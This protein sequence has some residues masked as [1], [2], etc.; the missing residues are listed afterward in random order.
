MDQQSM[1]LLADSANAW[2][3]DHS[4]LL[5]DLEQRASEPNYM[6]ELF[7]QLMALGWLDLLAASETRGDFALLA[8]LAHALAQHSA[9]LAVIVV[10]QNLAALLLAQQ[11]APAPNNWVTLPLLDA[12]SQWPYQ[13]LQW[14]CDGR[15][16]GQ[17]QSL[18]LLPVASSVLLPVF[19]PQ[20]S[21]FKLLQLPLTKK[22]KGL[23]CSAAVRTLGLRG[24]V[25]GDL[26]CSA[27][28]LDKSWLLAEGAQAQA[29]LQR[30]WSQAELCMM[31]VR[32][33]LAKA[34]YQ[35]ALEYAGQR[36][37]GGKIII[38]HSLICQMLADCYQQVVLFDEQWRAV[39]ALVNPDQP[40]NA[41]QQAMALISAE[42]LPALA[43]D[44]IQLL[45]GI[46]Y[47]EDF[48]QERRFRDAKHCEFLLGHPQA[49]RFALWQAA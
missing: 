17:W 47:M 9:S 22:L 12:P 6:A 7:D 26:Q 10:Q 43:S 24:C 45:G 30:L 13:P 44:G 3:V 46:G 33:G 11:D 40:L 36:Y 42:R 41:G 27:Q 38:E 25:Q 37:Q 20:H 4:A 23:K 15:L 8:A 29:D 1:S 21:G 14:S 5:A 39:A 31:A 18:S 34:C 35:T 2:A 32:A 48:A 19:G 16:E 28:T 49:K